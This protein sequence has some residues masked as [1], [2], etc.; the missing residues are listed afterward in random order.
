MRLRARL[1]LKTGP[2]HLSSIMTIPGGGRSIGGQG[3]GEFV[4]LIKSI[5]SF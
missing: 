2:N 5:N 4:T 3:P 1:R